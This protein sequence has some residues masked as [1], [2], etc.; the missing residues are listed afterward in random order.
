MMIAEPNAATLKVVIANWNSQL[1]TRIAV[2]KTAKSDANIT[3]VD[4]QAPFNTAINNPKSYGS[5]NTTCINANSKSCL[6][7]NN[8][9]PRAV[10]HKLVAQAIAINLNGT[11]F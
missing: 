4:T 10:I 2:F 7:F 5:P 6:R 3:L 8:Y 11:F 1:P 9:H